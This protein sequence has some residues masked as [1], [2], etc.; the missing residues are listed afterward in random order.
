MP[1]V[2]RHQPPPVA[3]DGREDA[4][5]VAQGRQTGP[6]PPSVVP[7]QSATSTSYGS[8]RFAALSRK[9]DLGRLDDAEDCRE[10]ASATMAL[11]S[12]A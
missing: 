6:G 12:V 9:G 1:V 4:A 5:M 11:R 3:G 10:V 7:G 2:P 8:S